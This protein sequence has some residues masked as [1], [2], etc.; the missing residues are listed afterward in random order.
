MASGEKSLLDAVK[1]NC[2]D[3]VPKYLTEPQY[4]KEGMYDVNMSDED[5]ATPLILA[6]IR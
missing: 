1:D 3:L 6:C 4:K 2:L 5:G